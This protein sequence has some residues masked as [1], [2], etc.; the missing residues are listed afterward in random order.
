MCSPAW[1]PDGISFSFSPEQLAL[2]NG[3]P[4]ADG[5]HEFHWW[6]KIATA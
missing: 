5:P 2:I 3:A 1:L 4:L 6:L